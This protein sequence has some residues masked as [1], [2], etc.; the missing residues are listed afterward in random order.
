MSSLCFGGRGAGRQRLQYVFL[1][2]PGFDFAEDDLVGIAAI[3]HVDHL[4]ARGKFAGLA[5]AAKHGAIELRFVDLAGIFPGSRLI[6]VRVRV[7]EEDV[8]VGAGGDA[9]SPSGA[10]IFDL[11]QGLEV[12]VEF[13]VTV[14]AA[15]RNPS[16]VVVINLQA[17]GKVEF[18]ERAAGL[19]AASLCNEATV[20]VVLHD[21]VVAVAVGDENIPLPVPADI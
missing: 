5:E 6:T 12:V 13:L 9:S 11:A 20:L 2:S 1:N 18:S 10:E 19:F 8:L 14:I 17:V 3:E 7:R 15:V 4:E 21:S 16:V